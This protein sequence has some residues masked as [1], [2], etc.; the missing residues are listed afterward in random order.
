MILAKD[1]WSKLSMTLDK[2]DAGNI[3][4]NIIFCIVLVINTDSHLSPANLWSILLSPMLCA[5]NCPTC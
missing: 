4:S 2:L 5:S 3:L 1:N